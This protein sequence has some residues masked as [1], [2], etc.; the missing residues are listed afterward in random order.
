MEPQYMMVR[1]IVLARQGDVAAGQAQWRRL[2]AY[3][4]QP[5]N[6]APETVLSRFMITPLVIQRASAALRD[7]GGCPGHACDLTR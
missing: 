7:S 1:A 2:L 6:A 4:R 5:A 3:T